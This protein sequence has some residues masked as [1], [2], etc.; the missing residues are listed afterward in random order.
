M[1]ATWCIKRL[2][3]NTADFST[4]EIEMIE[5]AL[6]HLLAIRDFLPTSA[7]PEPE[8]Q[9]NSATSATMLQRLTGGRATPEEITQYCLNDIVRRFLIDRRTHRATRF[10]GQFETKARLLGLFVENPDDEG[11]P[12]HLSL[13]DQAELFGE[14]GVCWMHAGRLNLARDALDSA[15]RCL[16]EL[17]LDLRAFQDLDANLT[18]EQWRLWTETNST[19]ALIQMRSGRICEDVDEFLAPAASLARSRALAALESP[20]APK[21]GE[22]L[23]A[24]RRLICRH[25]Q[26]ALQSGE[27][28]VAEAGYNLAAAV[29][30]IA[31]SGKLTGDALRRQIEVLVRRGPCLPEDLALAEAAIDAQLQP[32]RE[33]AN[34]RRGTSNDVIPMYVTKIMLLRAKGQFLD[35]QAYLEEAQR[36]E[37]VIRGECSFTARMELELE[38]YRLLIAQDAT[39]PATARAIAALAGELEARHHWSLYSDALLLQAEM[40]EEPDRTQLL[41][42]VNAQITSSQY[43]L[44]RTDI[45]IIRRGGSAV[46]TMGY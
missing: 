35:A 13:S 33:G 24:A 30:Q 45:D 3:A 46:K 20:A 41:N 19:L 39:T 15:T 9:P 2:P 37:F 21:N 36:H 4:T 25:A 38:K 11:R 5:G 17:G 7:S 14:I 43:L 44:R 16:S 26:L 6:Y 40:V 18:P 1:A 31:G 34:R 12:R 23:R 29:E 10:L 8:S 27:L 42:R 28:A 32:R 22:Q